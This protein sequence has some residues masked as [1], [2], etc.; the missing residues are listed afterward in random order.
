MREHIVA[1]R[2]LPD[3]RHG[4][5]LGIDGDENQIGLFGVMLRQRLGELR[6]GREMDEAVAIV[7][8]GPEKVLTGLGRAPDGLF[9]DFV[10]CRHLCALHRD[11]IGAESPVQGDE[12]RLRQMSINKAFPYLDLSVQE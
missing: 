1:P 8:L 7:V 6:G 10:D 4:K 11:P 2:S 12:R 9:A 3:E 5:R